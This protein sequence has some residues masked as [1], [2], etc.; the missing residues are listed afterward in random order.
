[1]VQGLKLLLAPLAWSFL[2]ATIKF[3]TL[4][5]TYLTAARPLIYCCLHRDILP[6]IIHVKPACPA[7]LVS[8][9]PDGDILI[10]TLGR[11]NYRFVRGGTGEDG[12]RAFLGLVRQ[13]EEGASVGVAVDG[14]KGPF[15]TIQEGILQLAR[16]TGAPILPLVARP[17]RAGSLSTWDRTVIPY[18]FTRVTFSHGALLEISRQA[19]RRDIDLAKAQL[20]RFFGVGEDAP[21]E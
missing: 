17:Q 6:A 11:Q 18:P 9:S 13:L 21:C 8:P 20:A 7:L 15:G 3:D 5:R 10:R 16:L 14:P 1:M 4:P 2:T 12:N 19:G